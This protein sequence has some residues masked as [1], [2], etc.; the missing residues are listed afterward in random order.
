MLLAVAPALVGVACLAGWIMVRATGR[1]PSPRAARRS[2]PP[3][4]PTSPR[5]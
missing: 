5:S 3:A 1:H 2:A 4:S